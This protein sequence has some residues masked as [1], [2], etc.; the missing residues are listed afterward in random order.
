MLF[1]LKG[2]RRRAVQVTYVM[3]AVLMG[4]GLVLFGIGGNVSGGLFDAFKGRG[5]GSSG[6]SLV[7]KNVER[8]EKRLAANP[9]DQAALKEIARGDYQLAAAGA[10]PQTGQFPKDSHDELEKSARAWERYLGLQPKKPDASLGRLM[11]Q[12]YS[13]IGLNR[14]AKAAEVA[15]IVADTSPNAQVYVLLTRYAA[16]AGQTR[17]AELAGRRALELAPKSQRS[18]VKELVKQAKAAGAAAKSGAGGVSAG[19]SP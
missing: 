15:E 12:V 4:G 8:A 18:T 5:G 3:L 9:K 1:D 7:K 16:L 2:R 10:D 6:N 13:E 11:L 19:G 17:K 14:P